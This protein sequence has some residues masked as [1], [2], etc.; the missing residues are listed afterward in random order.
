MNIPDHYF[1]NTRQVYISD[2]V[3]NYVPL[4]QMPMLEVL[5]LERRQLSKTPHH[6]CHPVVRAEDFNVAMFLAKNPVWPKYAHLYERFCTKTEAKTPRD[7]NIQIL[8]HA[9]FETVT[10][11]YSYLVREKSQDLKTN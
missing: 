2:Y 8:L 9:Y 10:D 7:R 4:R 6:V 1:T 3:G 11:N 5:V